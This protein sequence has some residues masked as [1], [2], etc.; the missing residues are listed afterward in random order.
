MK[1]ELE[2]KLQ[3]EFPFMRTENP[4]PIYDLECKINWNKAGGGDATAGGMYNVY[5]TYGCECGNGWYELI[6]GLCAEIGEAYKSRGLECDIV[7]V[8][9]KEKFG[10]LRFYWRTPGNDSGV[11][12]IDFLGLGSLRMSPNKS[13]VE[14]EVSEIV[15][16][17]EKKS[18]EICMLCGSEGAS[19]RKTSRYRVDTFCDACHLSRAQDNLEH[20]KKRLDEYYA[21]RDSIP[22][23]RAKNPVK[24]KIGWDESDLP[25][26][27]FL[28][29]GDEADETL[30]AWSIDDEEYDFSASRPN[31]YT[32]FGKWPFR[33]APVFVRQD[34]KWIC[35]GYNIHGDKEASN[36]VESRISRLEEDAAYWKKEAGREIILHVSPPGDNKAELV[37]CLLNKTPSISE[38][39]GLFASTKMFSKSCQRFHFFKLFHF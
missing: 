27:D 20:A 5:Q 22:E 10:T 21:K 18:G 34:G 11:H 17:W 36:N 8:Q 2:L 32:L 9:V 23:I 29:E 35:Q 30:V 31:G 28:Q 19:T 26:G 12:A 1:K 16:K 25:L 4:H 33:E 15:R 38:Y 39:S 3:A 24:T 7:V 6:R 14:L 13:D 37:C